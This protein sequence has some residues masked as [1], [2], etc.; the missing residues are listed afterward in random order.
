MKPT[1]LLP[2]AGRPRRRAFHDLTLGLDQCVL[3]LYASKS[4]RKMLRSQDKL[5]LA[6][7]WEQVVSELPLMQSAAE[8]CAADPKAVHDQIVNG[9]PGAALYI[10]SSM[11][12]DSLQ[13]ALP[14]FDVSQK[15]ARSRLDDQLMASEGEIALRIGRVFAMAS[16]VFGSPEQARDYLRTPNFALGGSVPRDLLKTASGEQIVLGELQAQDEGGPV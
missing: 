13:E 7:I 8:K 11:L 4:M 1:P 6:P 10:S 5:G 12:F 16:R 2:T 15:T 9:L 14:L 3:Q